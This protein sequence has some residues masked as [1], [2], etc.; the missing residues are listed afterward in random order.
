MFKLALLQMRVEPGAK[1]ENL[2]RA[3]HRIAEAADAGA[4]VALLPEAMNVGWTGPGAPQFADDIPNGETCALLRT[5]AARHR[6]Y[7]CAGLVERAPD[8]RIY[9][10][11]VLISLAG[12]VLLHHRKIHELEMAHACYGP[13]DRLGVAETSLGRI[14]IMIC[15]DAFAPGQVISRTLGLM[16]ADVI[17]SPCAWAVPADHDNV[18]EP[19][20]QLWLDNYVPVA[21][22]YRMWIAGVSN[23]GPISSGPWAGRT[24]IGSSLVI[25]G[26]GN[27]VLQGPYGKEAEAVLMVDV[28]PVA[29]PARGT[30]WENIWKR[31]SEGGRRS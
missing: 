19:Y 4:Q 3:A 8:Q 26:A 2:K 13:G 31:Q 16:G 17:L 6:I 5:L 18:R 30:G 12:D 14:G 7:L 10:S 23:V 27:K 22:D 24:C 11:A 25:D 28:H 9:N 1:A 20:G 15:A 29:R 21:R